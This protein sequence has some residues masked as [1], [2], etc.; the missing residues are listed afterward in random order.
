MNISKVTCIISRISQQCQHSSED[1]L[2]GSQRSPGWKPQ[3]AVT[4]QSCL[5]F[6]ELR[7]LY[8]GIEQAFF[9][10]IKQELVRNSKESLCNSEH[11]E[12]EY[13]HHHL[14]F[15]TPKVLLYSPS[16]LLLPRLLLLPLRSVRV[17]SGKQNHQESNRIEDL[18]QDPALLWRIPEHKGPQIMSNI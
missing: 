5:H 17:H 16:F 18:L 1:C 10:F 7:L 8:F 14:G 13:Y 6:S 4:R 11:F 3:A 15:I 9:S 12:N 2:Q